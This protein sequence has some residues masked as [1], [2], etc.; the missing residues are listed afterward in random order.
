MMI[1]NA[2]FDKKLLV[3]ARRG[4]GLI[5]ERHF[6]HELHLIVRLPH[7]DNPRAV[8][9]LVRYPRTQHPRVAAGVGERMIDPGRTQP[10][11]DRLDRITFGNSAEINPHTR[12]PKTNRGR[13]LIE[14]HMTIVNRR[15]ALVDLIGRGPRTP[16]EI[17][18]LPD[19][20]VGDVEGTAGAARQFEGLPN[21]VK[22]LT[23]TQPAAASRLTRE[24][25][26]S[27]R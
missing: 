19:T 26:E 20:V 1:S 25:S 8:A 14:L 2:G 21:Q 13:F 9:T 23:G 4:Y 6:G 11:N 22:E 3:V 24:I 12:M 5:V 17:V 15:Q 7:T 27:S 16:L 18:E 10:A